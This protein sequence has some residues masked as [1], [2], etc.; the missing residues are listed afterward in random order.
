[1]TADV[2]PERIS[3]NISFNKDT[4]EHHKFFVDFSHHG[5]IG[6]DGVLIVLGLCFFEIVEPIIKLIKLFPKQLEYLCSALDKKQVNAHFLIQ[7]LSEFFNFLSGQKSG[8][9]VTCSVSSHALLDLSIGFFLISYFHLF[10]N[11]G[12]EPLLPCLSPHLAVKL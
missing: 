1:M 4:V 5:L 3:H 2:V 7:L 8:F 9:L 10:R 6:V 11:L 12:L